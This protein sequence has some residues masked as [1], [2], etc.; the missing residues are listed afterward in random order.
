MASM[1]SDI[2]DLDTAMK[3]YKDTLN[4]HPGHDLASYNA[5]LCYLFKEEFQKGWPNYDLRWKTMK[6]NGVYLPT[7]ETN[8]EPW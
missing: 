5:A 1:L 3:Y 4:L 2:G 6:N 7:G 8:V